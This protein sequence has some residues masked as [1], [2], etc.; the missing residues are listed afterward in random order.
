[1]IK[2]L[3]KISMV[4][5][6]LGSLLS[7]KVVSAQM[8]GSLIPILL[9]KHETGYW[10][11]REETTTV[12]AVDTDGDGIVDSKDACPN[13]KGTKKNNGC[14]LSKKDR[15]I[16]KKA[17]GNIFFESGSATIKKESHESLKTLAGLLNK[18]PEIKTTVEGHTDKTG[19]EGKNV[20][21]SKKRAQAVVDFLVKNGESIENIDAKGVGSAQPVASNDT[22]DGKAQNRRVEIVVTLLEVVKQ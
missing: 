13:I 6:F 19:D 12:A 5:V 22:E 10:G 8:P 14:P 21:L 18:H 20:E 11:D 9:L 2:N 16:I 3:T 4:I 17:S 1:M 7:A 15:E